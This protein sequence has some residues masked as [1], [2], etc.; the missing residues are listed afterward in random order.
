ME[1]QLDWMRLD[2]ALKI[3]RAQYKKLW[4]DMENMEENSEKIWNIWKKSELNS[5]KIGIGIGWQTFVRNVIIVPNISRP[6]KSR[7]FLK[8]W[9]SVKLPDNFQMREHSW[10]CWFHIMHYSL[11]EKIRLPFDDFYYTRVPGF[12]GIGRTR[13]G[14]RLH[15]HLCALC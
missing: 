8:H 5:Q 2:S 10:P 14:T 12:S 6:K 13:E 1:R 9:M 4:N 7:H 3:S 11:M 15:D